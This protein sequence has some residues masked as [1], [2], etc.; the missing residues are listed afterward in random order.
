M[1]IRSL[2]VTSDDH[3]GRYD[4]RRREQKSVSGYIDIG[5]IVSHHK[6]RLRTDDQ[7]PGAH[8]EQ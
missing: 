4:Q 6:R 8:Q 1:L 3:I 5:H 2:S 7:E